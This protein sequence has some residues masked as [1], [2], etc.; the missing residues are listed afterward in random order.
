MFPERTT[1]VLLAEELGE[2]A[3]SSRA[4]VRRAG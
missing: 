1:P 4:D 2:T 3:E